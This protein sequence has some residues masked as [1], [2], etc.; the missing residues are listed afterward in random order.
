M[1]NRITFLFLAV[2]SAVAV[3]QAGAPAGAASTNL[4]QSVL[5]Y[6][7]DNLRTG[8]NTNETTLTPSNV[9]VSTFGK[10]HS[11]PLD[12]LA[13]GQPLYVPSLQIR[14]GV[15]N[16]VFVITENNSVYAFDA[17]FKV[18][19]PL[20]HTNLGIPVPCSASQPVS[21]SN[22]NLVYLT[23]V[24]GITATPVIDLTQG[25]HG[26]I[27]V[28]GRTDPN[29]AGKYF[30]VLHKYDL[31][32]GKDL[33][34]SPVVIKGSVHGTGR[35]NVNGIVT[36]NQASENDRGALLLANGIVYVPF[37]SINDAPIFHGWIFGY[38]ATTMKRRYIFNATPNNT[39]N[40]GGDGEQGGIWNGTIEADANNVLFTVT[41]NGSWDDT[42]NDWGN[43][44]LK[45]H[46]STGKLQVTD[47]FTPA[48]LAFDTHDTDL[49]TN[50]AILL[51][52]QTGT[53]P[54]VML[55]GD[56]NGTVYV[57]NRDNMG[58]YDSSGDQILQEIPGA[59]GVHIANSRDCN[60]T[61]NDC[62]YGTAAYWNGNVYFSGVNDNVKAFAIANGQLSGP[63]SKSP[64]TYG[65][66]GATPSVSS[67][68][69]SNG[70]V[71]VVQP[72]IS[73][74][75]AYDA[76]N[77]A[78]ELYNS[79]QASGGR[80]SLGSN[81]KFAPPTVVNGKVYIGTKSALVVYGLL[82]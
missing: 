68:G 19:T 76:T 50:A 41:G 28:E 29:H 63:T 67:S 6:H 15:H 70:I 25:T 48:A 79:T 36:F 43:S 72:I 49:G 18:S 53:Y 8:E 17:D 37:A 81:T 57:V 33:P 52:D 51:P 78:N 4:T 2:L 12:S 47:F 26:A 39:T 34:G 80:D 71:W 64:T 21:G 14:G 66:P 75:H 54:H 24:I 31:S 59:V 1:G 38:D 82:K 61:H 32:T 10:L 58:K 46:P 35:D 42:V 45:L 56:K 11:F 23:S 27:Y 40:H 55:S 22:C 5:T 74:L 60:S 65:F 13:Y 30:H 73:I 77:L 16:V 20:W 62:N 9:N 44:Y 3:Y 69:T 7:N